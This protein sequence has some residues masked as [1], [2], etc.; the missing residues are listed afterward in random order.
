[1]RLAQRPL[2][3]LWVSDC[4]ALP[5]LFQFARERYTLRD[6]GLSGTGGPPPPDFTAEE[7][8]D[9]ARTPRTQAHSLAKVGGGGP[10]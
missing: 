1:M 7:E 3:A 2:T 5:T 10:T 6:V 8:K 4:L 9:G